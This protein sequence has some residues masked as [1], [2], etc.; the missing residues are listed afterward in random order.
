MD[1]FSTVV[2]GWDWRTEYDVNIHIIIEALEVECQIPCSTD[3]PRS[4]CSP[5]GWKPR[6]GFDFGRVYL[7]SHLL[8]V[9]DYQAQIGIA[10]INMF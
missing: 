10:V 6:K 9:L 4:G 3:L 8:C 5:P 1:G 7:G 2:D